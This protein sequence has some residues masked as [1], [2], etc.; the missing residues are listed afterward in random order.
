MKCL[1]VTTAFK[2]NAVLL[3]IVN[4]MLTFS[5]TILNPVV[6]LSL[7]NSKLRK[8]LC[9]FMI[10]ILA[11][12]DLAVVVVIHPLIIFKIISCWMSADVTERW[13]WTEY[14]YILFNFSSKGLLTMTLERYLALLHPFSH[15]K[16]VKKSRLMTAFVLFQLP[17]AILF[18]FNKNN[19][20]LNLSAYAV[21]GIVF[22]LLCIMMNLKLFIVARRLRKS[23]VITL[24]NFDG[25]NS[26]TRNDFD[27]KKFKLAFLSLEKISTCLS[28]VVCLIICN[29]PW[30]TI[31]GIEISNVSISDQ[32]MFIIGHWAATI[33]ALN[34]SLNCLIFFYKNSVLRRHGKNFLESCFSGRFRL[35][36]I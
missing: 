32:N 9:Y 33:C 16:F 19:R 11:C 13:N 35:H 5:G 2:W 24:G 4:I 3:C 29:L 12:S 36:Y 8:K 25:S 26:E 22:F 20:S 10:F 7:W 23:A 21:D 1:S 31:V 28:A 17:L 6:I 15:Q 34:S 27:S 14:I 18:I 30:A